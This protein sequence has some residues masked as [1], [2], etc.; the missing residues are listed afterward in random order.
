MNERH[1]LKVISL[2]L[3]MIAWLLI[4]PLTYVER[5]QAVAPKEIPAFPG[6]EGFGATTPGGRGGKV[7]AVTNLN[8]D[9]PGSL[10]AAC[11]EGISDD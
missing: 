8:D 9:G 1:R 5:T 10:R 4:G 2:G 6:A 7:I 11:D 3:L